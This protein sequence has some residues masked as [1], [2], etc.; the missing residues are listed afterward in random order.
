MT[1]VKPSDLNYD[2][3]AAD[4]YDRDIVNAIPFHKELHEH[5]A[6]YINSHFDTEKE[7]D[8]IDLGTGTG[9]T[10]KVIQDLLPKARIDA[11]DFSEQM[12]AGAK[13]KLGDENVHYL[14]GDFAEMAFD[15]RYDIVLAVIG[16]HHQDT[17][18]K[19]RLFQKIYSTLKSGGV[20]IFGDLVTY[21]DKYEAAKNEALH[22]HA[23][24]EHA[25]DDKMLAEWAH[26][27]QFLNDLAPI[28]EQI[29]WLSQAGFK[30]HKDFLK[31]QTALL[32]CLKD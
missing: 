25:T 23:L 10:A 31:I 2:S 5:I 20:F 29:E 32:F 15:K 11:V 17:E 6:D 4:K 12:M 24:V 3:Y 14:V 13:A 27:H 9:I 21:A 7:Y 30:V 16:V 26:H 19:K 8:V 1:N 28:E 18:G 22:Y